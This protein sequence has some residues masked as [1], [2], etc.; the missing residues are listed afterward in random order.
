M[1]FVKGTVVAECV[2]VGSIRLSRNNLVIQEVHQGLM[3]GTQVADPNH[4][5]D[6]GLQAGW[7]RVQVI[8]P[9]CEKGQKFAEFERELE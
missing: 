2:L 1:K 9:G 3:R 8:L 7:G 6:I 5:E 4:Q